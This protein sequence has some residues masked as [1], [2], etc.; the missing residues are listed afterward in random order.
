MTA[1]A[2]R[3]KKPAALPGAN[4]AGLVTSELSLVKLETPPSVWCDEY[5][6]IRKADPEAEAFLGLKAGARQALSALV[7]PADAHI[8]FAHLRRC[9]LPHSEPIVTELRMVPRGRTARVELASVTVPG[10]GAR[11]TRTTILER[12]AAPFRLGDPQLLEHLFDTLQTPIVVLDAGLRLVKGNRDFFRLFRL[13][14]PQALKLPFAELPG[15]SF[16]RTLPRRLQEVL[17]SGVPLI[18]YVVQC[19]VAHAAREFKFLLNARRF[20]LGTDQPYLALHLYNATERIEAERQ[21]EHLLQRLRRLSESLEARVGRRTSALRVANERLQELSSELVDAQES[22]RRHLACELHDQVGQSLTALKLILNNISATIP[23]AE[24]GELDKAQAIVNELMAQV[25][26]LSANLRPQI[27]D[28]LGLKA[29]ITWQVAQFRALAKAR[30]SLRFV[31]FDEDS[32]TPGA[33]ITLFRVVQES[34]TN[35]LKH[36]GAS[37]VQVT[38]TSTIRFVSVRVADNGRGFTRALRRGSSTGLSGLRERL[39]LLGGELQIRSTPRM[40][41]TILA[42]LPLSRETAGA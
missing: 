25:R 41:T 9:R 35:V 6:Y 32:L 29:A 5:S 13:S 34:L 21:R 4:G 20:T 19:K 14:S 38:V 8:F 11:L 27:L 36:A 3:S 39:Q 26:Q 42:R 16:Q 23:P 1:A 17:T 18:S 7:H 37:E 28:D 24:K 10:P 12:G 33:I 2:K 15:V 30:I 31:N 22:E 40:G